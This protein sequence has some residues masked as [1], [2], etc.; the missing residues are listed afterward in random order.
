MTKVKDLVRRI[1]IDPDQRIV[2]QGWTADLPWKM[3][4]VMLQ[5]LRAPD[6][7]FC[8]QTKILCRWMRSKVLKNADKK[9]TFMCRKDELPPIEDL[10][11]ELNYCSMHF[12]TH[13]LYAM[14]IIG[15]KH[16]D[17]NTKD[18]AYRYY[19]ELVWGI[20][21]F[22]IEPEADLDGR[23]EDVDK[24]TEPEDCPAENEDSYLRI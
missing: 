11:N 23:L 10:E 1:R 17:K 15:Y 22:N 2:L 13:F 6:T 21:H 5:G 19:E 8:K 3:Q 7:H 18:I 16:P 20:M 9:H 24:E 12:T 14:E 4:T